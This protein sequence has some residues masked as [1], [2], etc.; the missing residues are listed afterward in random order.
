MVSVLSATRQRR[1]SRFYP[2]RVKLVLDLASPVGCKAELTWLPWLHT[3]VVYPP[4]DGHPSHT[5]RA[6]RWATSFMRRTRCTTLNR[7]YFTAS[8]RQSIQQIESTEFE[9]KGARI[10]CMHAATVRL[11]ACPSVL[12]VSCCL[13]SSSYWSLDYRRFAAW[14]PCRNKSAFHDTDILAR[15][16]RGGACRT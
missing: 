3:E 11:F 1:Q 5:D 6:Q 4:E 10:S 9:H 14:R 12:V 13:A 7:Q 2:S 8:A 16:N 15:G